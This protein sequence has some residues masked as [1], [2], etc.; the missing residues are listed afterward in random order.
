MIGSGPFE[1]VESVQNE[2]VT[3]ATNTDYWRTPPNVDEVIFQ[4][5][6]NPDARVAA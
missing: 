6:D 4:T 3:L 1:L 5:I 2:H